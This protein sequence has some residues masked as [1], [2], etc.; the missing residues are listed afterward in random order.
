MLGARLRLV[1]HFL[2]G[3]AGRSQVVGTLPPQPQM[4]F[5]AC[6]VLPLVIDDYSR[7][8]PESIVVQT[9]NDRF[10]KL[11]RSAL[12]SR[13]PS[14]TAPLRLREIVSRR[15]SLAFEAHNSLTATR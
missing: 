2:A 10:K 5:Q 6:L 8:W 3:S 11:T 12:L 7:W 13:H 9:V 1:S 14:V 15:R 4:L